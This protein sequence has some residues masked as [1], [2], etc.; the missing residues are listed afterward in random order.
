MPV[1]GKN[2]NGVSKRAAAN[3]IAAKQFPEQFAEATPLS[4][5]EFCDLSRGTLSP[6]IL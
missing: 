5:R 3:H 6:Q 1:F 2:G 4:A